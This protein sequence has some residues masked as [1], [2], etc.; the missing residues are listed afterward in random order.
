MAREPNSLPE[1]CLDAEMLV[2]NYTWDGWHSSKYTSV[3]SVSYVFFFIIYVYLY[4][5]DIIRTNMYTHMYDYVHIHS[6]MQ[7]FFE[8]T[9]SWIDFFIH[10]EYIYIY[11]FL[12]TV[13]LFTY[14]HLCIYT[15][16]G[17]CLN[18]TS[19]NEHVIVVKR[20]GWNVPFDSPA[21]FFVRSCVPI[22]LA[23]GPR[24]CWGT[25]G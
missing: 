7:V 6:E 16:L 4:C 19:L 1:L 24:F 25:V 3:S 11:I 5:F 17:R 18:K 10:N 15:Y 21:P 14:I 20:D 13:Y 9:M 2:L 8:C 22:V 12:F 23:Q